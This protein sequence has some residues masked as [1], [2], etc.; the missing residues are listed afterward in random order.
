MI[1]PQQL[2]SGNLLL[3]I[4]GG[5]VAAVVGAI[6]WAA[7]TAATSFQIGFMSLGVAYIVAYALRIA[8]RGHDQRFSYAGAILSL[9]GCVLG[10]FL[11]TCAIFAKQEHISIVV[12][13]TLGALHFV[14]LM[15]ETFN[16]M[17]LAFYAIAAWYGFKYAQ[18]PLRFAQPAPTDA[19]PA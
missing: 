12:A 14:D 17:D 7:I 6:V 11:A 1:S 13:V 9:F 8:G 15:R 3:G 19:P 10:N 4:L 5:L 16:I 2:R 18:S